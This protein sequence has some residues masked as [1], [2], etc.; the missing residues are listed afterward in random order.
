MLNTDRADFKRHLKVLFAAYTDFP[1][2]DEQEE[3]Y[4]L[5]LHHARLSEVVA[6][7]AKL[8]AAAKK[9]V[10][11]PRPGD[12]LNVQPVDRQTKDAK[13]EAA[14]A[15]AEKFSARTWDEF[16]RN[17]PE[18][19]RI[20]L[21]IAQVGRILAR[22]HES[23]PQYAEAARQDQRLRYQRSELWRERAKANPAPVWK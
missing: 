4:W 14:F 6:N 17:D 15:A 23:T 11:V 5:G 19:A 22:D 9:G 10:P 2:R 20:D 12:L 7:I 8:C 1:M 21:G 18:L 3:A 16:L 13:V